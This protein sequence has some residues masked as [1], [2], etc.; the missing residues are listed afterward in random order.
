MNL[1]L[2]FL[3]RERQCYNDEV[4][5]NNYRIEDSVK[6]FDHHISIVD[7]DNII[8]KKYCKYYSQNHIRKNCQTNLLQYSQTLTLQ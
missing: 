2:S 8:E 5:W 1:P 7:V 4:R 6:N 3:S